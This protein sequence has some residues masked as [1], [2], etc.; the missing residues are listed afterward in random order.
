MTEEIHA[1]LNKIDESFD[2][3]DLQKYDLVFEMEDKIFGYSI[4]DVEKNKFIALGYFRNHLAEVV[5]AFPWLGGKF[6][7]STG[8]IGNSRFTLIPEALYQENE[9]EHYF[10]FLHEREAG[11]A[12]F[13]DRIEHLGMYTVYSVPAHCRRELEKVFPNVAL[14]HISGVLIRMIWMMVKNKTG[15]KVFLNL[16]EGQFDLLVFDGNQLKYCN[17]FHFNTPEDIAYY[18]IF[19]F[20]QLNLNPEEINLALLGNVEKFSPVFD[21]LFRYVRNI[22]FLGRNERFNYSYMFNDIPGHYYYTLLN[23]SS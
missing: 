3:K 7:S 18:V 5:S 21:L 2:E 16:R 6:H 14:C 20:E 19:V 10:G 8:I 1:I 23:P 17:A 22:E 15:R 13:S 9:T 11:E 4:R 12:V